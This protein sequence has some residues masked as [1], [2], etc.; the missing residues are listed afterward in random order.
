[1]LQPRLKIPGGAL[2]HSGRC[3]AVRLHPLD[4][5]DGEVIDQAQTV[6]TCGADV[7]M[8]RLRFSRRSHR[9]ALS[10]CLAPH[11]SRKIMVPSKRLTPTSKLGAP[12]ASSWSIATRAATTR[13]S[14]CVCVVCIFPPP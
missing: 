13:L 9:S 3:E 2:N 4:G 11:P 8:A 5:G 1:M 12:M 14:N 10:T 7:N 6:Q